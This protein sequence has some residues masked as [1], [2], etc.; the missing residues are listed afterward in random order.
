MLTL[1]PHRSILKSVRTLGPW[2]RGSEQ[3]ANR[4]GLA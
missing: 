2:A 4:T 1:S 3:D